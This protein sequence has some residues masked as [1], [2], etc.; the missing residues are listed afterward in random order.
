MRDELKAEVDEAITTAWAAPDPD[1]E[2]ALRHVFAEDG[3][4]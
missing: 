2:T 1:P 3:D 4:V